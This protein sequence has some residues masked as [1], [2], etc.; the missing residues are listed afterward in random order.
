MMSS[1][2]TV[3]RCRA[4][5]VTTTA[6]LVLATQ[7]PAQ[8]LEQASPETAAVMVRSY[9]QHRLH[10]TGRAPIVRF[11]GELPQMLSGIDRLE[12]VADGLISS[13]DSLCV[14]DGPPPSIARSVA[15]ISIYDASVDSSGARLMA[16]QIYGE[17]W[18]AIETARFTHSEAWDLREIAFGRLAQD[19]GTY[20]PYTTRSNRPASRPGFPPDSGKRQR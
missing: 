8:S 15:T 17:R 9:L 5:C 4:V 11:C 2:V 12:L 19:N 16:A 13:I 10:V 1:I 14:D 18:Y 7:L 3:T 6:S 20:I